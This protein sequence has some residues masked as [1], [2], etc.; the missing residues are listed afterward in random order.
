MGGM[1]RGKATEFWLVILAAGLLAVLTS[2]VLLEIGDYWFAVWMGA[3]I[4]LTILSLM[5]LFVL[6]EDRRKARE[7]NRDI[8]EELALICTQG[9]QI[10]RWCYAAANAVP[11]RPAPGEAAEIWA[12]ALSQFLLK[13]L[14]ADYAVRAVTP[15]GVH[16][17]TTLDEPHCSVESFVKIR[18]GRL[19]DFMQELA[20]RE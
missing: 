17:V 6:S 9:H 1:E 16:G 19:V 14:G 13:T 20:A 4:G 10:I 7:R 18:I 12:K 8:R 5:C 11:P 2:P 3:G 15:S